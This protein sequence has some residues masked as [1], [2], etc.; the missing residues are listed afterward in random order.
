MVQTRPL[1]AARAIPGTIRHVSS[2]WAMF[3]LIVVLKI[4]I[5]AL[6]YIVWWATREPPV[7]DTDSGDGGSGIERDPHPRIRPPQPPRRGPHSGRPPSAPSRTR[8]AARRRRV[9]KR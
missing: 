3:W 8:V 5:A 2:F 7:P 1:L 6:F 4:P 9:P